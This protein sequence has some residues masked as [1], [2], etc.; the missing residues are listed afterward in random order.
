MKNTEKGL[1]CHRKK[2][3]PGLAFFYRLCYS[4]KKLKESDTSCI[5]ENMTI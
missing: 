4:M 1:E 5:I 2:P 3:P